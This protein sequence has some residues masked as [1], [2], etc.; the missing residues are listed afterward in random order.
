MC[1]APGSS[2]L[3]FAGMMLLRRGCVLKGVNHFV[4]RILSVLQAT[5][6]TPL[7]LGKWV[8]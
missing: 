4:P 1:T 8:G 5:S 6:T 3:L 2:T 7:V